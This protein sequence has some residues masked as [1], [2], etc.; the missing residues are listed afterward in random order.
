MYVKMNFGP[1][2]GKEIDISADAANGL[3]A[4]GRASRAF[5]ECAPAPVLVLQSAPVKPAAAKKSTKR[6]S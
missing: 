4:D 6:N 5:I 3:L 1:N 2:A